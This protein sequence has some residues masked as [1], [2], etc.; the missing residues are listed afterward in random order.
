MQIAGSELPRDSEGKIARER[1]CYNAH[2]MESYPADPDA[3][4]LMRTL[5]G[6]QQ[7]NVGPPLVG[8]PFFKSFLMGRCPVPD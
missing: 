6:I 2:P 5:G 4:P 3:E 8:E 7:S 1:A